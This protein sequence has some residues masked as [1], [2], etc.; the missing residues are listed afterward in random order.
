MFW[1]K[2]FSN[3]EES[4]QDELKVV[5]LT[6]TGLVRTNNE[7]SAK[8]IKPSRRLEHLGYLGIV[9]DGM[10]GHH[11]GEVASTL[12]VEII[13]GEYYKKADDPETGLYLAFSKANRMI[14]K[15]ART[16]AAF[17][18]MGTTCTAVV[19]FNS[20]VYL[21]HIG[22]SRLY[23]FKQGM[24]TQLS[25]DHTY[26]QE[27]LNQG[28]ISPEEAQVHQERNVL[29]RVLGTQYSLR[30]DIMEIPQSFEKGDRLLLCSDGLY[31]YF[32]R[33]ELAG[34]LTEPVLGN[35][36]QNLVDAAR[37]RGG[38]DNITVLLIEKVP[39]EPSEPL[40][41]TRETHLS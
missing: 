5:V 25:T 15:K 2:W 39:S 12:A 40:R 29:T 4:L 35:A 17:E 16:N 26:V 13:A 38:Y 20:K 14:W 22:D 19:I 1:K 24:L 34:Y 28:V 32:S 37:Q 36:A 27:L 7:D 33:E 18:G 30:A 21:A 10:G 11:A 3:K 6:D 9:A 8:F 23:L 41:P 31:D